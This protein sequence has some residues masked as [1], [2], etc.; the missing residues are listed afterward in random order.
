MNPEEPED[1]YINMHREPGSVFVRAMV[2]I[3]SP[4]PEAGSN[5][6][7]SHDSARWPIPF[8]VHELT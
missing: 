8:P 2:E 7:P 4:E 3:I 5:V 6:W 1:T